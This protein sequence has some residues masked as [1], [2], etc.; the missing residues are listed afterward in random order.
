MF[1]HGPRFCRLGCFSSIFHRT[2]TSTGALGVVLCI[3]WGKV[4]AILLCDRWWTRRGLISRPRR[5]GMRGA[6]CARRACVRPALRA[7]CSISAA[8]T[9]TP[10]DWAIHHRRRPLRHPPALRAPL[11]DTAPYAEGSKVAFAGAHSP[12]R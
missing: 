8:G 4:S 11:A 7:H 9:A 10:P 12:P 3:I 6:W 2:V 5:V 1:A